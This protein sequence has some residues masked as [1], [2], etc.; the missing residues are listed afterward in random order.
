MT[1]L[2]FIPSVEYIKTNIPDKS[3]LT[4]KDENNRFNDVEV[5]IF[6][7]TEDNISNY[8]LCFHW[9]D[10]M[11]CETYIT[12][13]YMIAD[14]MYYEELH[15]IPF[16]SNITLEDVLN[17]NPKLVELS[18]KKYP[19]VFADELIKF[20]KSFQDLVN[21]NKQNWW[22]KPNSNEYYKAFAKYDILKNLFSKS[23]EIFA[24][25][26]RLIELNIQQEQY[27]YKVW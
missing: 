20:N 21:I 5:N 10:G 8:K 17:E 16:K 22:I 3:I 14:K 12:P 24:Y 15:I 25:R 6:N 2:P 19:I 7:L 27:E 4:I 11:V 9:G 23:P 26:Q 1:D 18:L 13:K